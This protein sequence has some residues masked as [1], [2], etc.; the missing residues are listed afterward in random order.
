MY[1]KNCKSII[2]DDSKFCMYCGQ[3]IENINVYTS[4]A[5]SFDKSNYDKNDKVYENES[6]EELNLDD[7][8]KT[9]IDDTKDEFI[10]NEDLNKDN[11][12]NDVQTENLDLINDSTD[13]QNDIKNDDEILNVSINRS[14]KKSKK[15]YSS[16]KYVFIALFCI[17]CFLF[18]STSIFIVNTAAV[19]MKKLYNYGSSII[20]SEDL[21]AEE[22]VIIVEDSEQNSVTEI[23]SLEDFI[24]FYNDFIE[25]WYGYSQY[26]IPDFNT[27]SNAYSISAGLDDGINFQISVDDKDT[28]LKYSV[29]I[30][31]ENFNNLDDEINA[32]VKSVFLT[33]NDDFNFDLDMKIDT[34]LRELLMYKEW[35]FV[36]ENGVYK[37]KVEDNGHFEFKFFK[38]ND[39]FSSSFS[40]INSSYASRKSI[41]DF[42]SKF[43]Q[44]SYSF[45]NG[46]IR[47][48]LENAMADI[49]LNFEEGQ[50]YYFS[51][52]NDIFIKINGDLDKY[53]L[54]VK[55]YLN[56]QEDLET[57]MNSIIKYVE[58]KSLSNDDI[59]NYTYD[60]FDK[61]Y[62]NNKTVFLELQHY[63]IYGEFS[64]NNFANIEI[65][66]KD[67]SKEEFTDDNKD[68]ENEQSEVSN[69]LPLNGYKSKNGS[70]IMNFTKDDFINYYNH[71]IEYIQYMRENGEFKKS[72]LI[73]AN[74]DK[75]KYSLNYNIEYEFISSSQDDNKLEEIKIYASPETKEDFSAVNFSIK[76]LI[77]IFKGNENLNLDDNI[78]NNIYWGKFNQIE[79]N[80]FIYKGSYDSSNEIFS[81]SIRKFD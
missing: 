21:S 10:I 42:I 36:F 76:S 53:T 41:S 50:K 33:M 74:E 34:F 13:I 25:N 31:G 59:E 15:P 7:I 24:N 19:K 72:L 26:K 29:E 2:P 28:V 47:I 60:F 38:E 64:K 51:I 71:Y 8:S 22:N 16:Y 52:G 81:F 55:N 67:Y 45:G 14:N 68:E 46:H 77:A 57:V 48:D 75:D 6:L 43:N 78:L 27:D 62:E 56:N 3:N 30:T 1:C 58:T 40:D 54:C 18:V 20:Y 17:V 5:L 35:Y 80:G 65:A 9:E 70:Y 61:M 73:P 79:E 12:K 44:Y 37:G 4:S 66:K 11:A 49:N 39:P 23:Y 69:S 63:V 32:I